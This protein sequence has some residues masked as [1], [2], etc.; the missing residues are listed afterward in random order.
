MTTAGPLRIG[1]LGA[2]RISA[3]SLVGPAPAGGH[4]LVAVA[5][6]TRVVGPSR[7]PGRPHGPGLLQPARPAHA[8]AL[9]RWPPHLV[10]ARGGARQGAPD[11]DEW[12][13]AEL[14]FPNGATGSARCHMAYGDV[15]MSFRVVGSRA[16]RRP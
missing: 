8:R 4:R 5:T 10:T 13:D 3:L 1:I 2:A 14:A 15:R 6:R 12:L 11:V 9:G 7:R 16:R